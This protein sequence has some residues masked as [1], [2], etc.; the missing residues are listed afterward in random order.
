MG[1]ILLNATVVE[2]RVRPLGVVIRDI[3]VNDLPE[4]RPAEEETVGQAFVLNLP[5]KLLRVVIHDRRSGRDDL[6]Q[7]A[8]PGK[9]PVHLRCVTPVTVTVADQEAGIRAEGILAF[10]GPP[11]DRVQQ[12]FG[13]AVLGRPGDEHPL[14][15]QMD[16]EQGIEGPLPVIGPDLGREEIASPRNLLETLEKLF[17]R[18]AAHDF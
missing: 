17:P 2:F 7:N 16:E 8:D 11:P 15:L 6:R 10:A 1:V 12:P 9:I 18:D 4:R 14:G 5:H 3:I 13:G